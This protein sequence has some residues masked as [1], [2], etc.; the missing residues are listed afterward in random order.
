MKDIIMSL[1]GQVRRGIASTSGVSRPVAHC[2]R[3]LICGMGGS[4]ISG[5][6][7][8]AL[9]PEV[10]VIS[11]KDYRLPSVITRSTVAILVSYSGNT[12]ETMANYAAL[13]RLRLPIVTI[14]SGGL[15]ARKP[16]TLRIIVPAGLP[17]RGALGHLFTPIPMV[18]HRFGLVRHDPGPGLT[19]LAGFL[20]RWTARL[21]QRARR[22]A[23]RLVDRLPVIYAVSPLTSV[24]ANRW[25]CQLNEN[26]KVMCHTNVIPEMNHNEIVGFGNP[27]FLSGRIGVIF[28]HDPDAHPRNRLRV[29]IIKDIIRR[30]S[31]CVID[32]V[33]QGADSLQRLFWTIML[34]DLVSYH[35]A[36]ITG[37][38][39]LPVKR[40]AYLKDQLARN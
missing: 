33:P 34:G 4:G 2:D 29:R 28:L 27:G 7:A 35:L 3:A 1:P 39:P 5:E 24:A 30:D 23:R 21:D 14:T 25:R 17:P 37:V 22:L 38:D 40:I 8:A 18:L 12:E 13:T 9:Y 31:A 32:I 15:L 26:A 6:I 10:T 20:E 16:A 36:T 19:R 11:N